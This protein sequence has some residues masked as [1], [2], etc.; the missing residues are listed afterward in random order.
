MATTGQ[1]TVLSMI[2]LIAFTPRPSLGQ[3]AL[4]TSDTRG[5]M[6]FDGIYLQQRTDGSPLT[7]CWRFFADGTAAQS[8]G[9]LDRPE[10]CADNMATSLE[11]G[12]PPR[13]RY[14]LE[15]NRLEIPRDGSA[16]TAE[17][18]VLRLQRGTWAYECRFV[19]DHELKATTAAAQ[20]SAASA[21]SA[22]VAP[23]AAE[24][25]LGR[26][27]MDSSCQKVE[28]T[29]AASPARFPSRVAEI[30]YRIT[31]GSSDSRSTGDLR[32]EDDL[33]CSTPGIESRTC[34]QYGV[35][36]GEPALLSST[37]I[38][39]CADGKPFQP[40]T[41]RLDLIRDGR[42]ARSIEFEIG[43]SNP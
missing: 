14:T 13:Y 10:V 39:R 5:P 21:R 11:Y 6:R 29:A 27:S 7:T 20:S 18:D 42:R 32:I 31:L 17:G 25:A 43:A 37:I 2:A 26:A 8:R 41:Y 1:R 12:G 35:V 22:T 15:G 36:M 9:P 19:S 4:A 38:L 34:N 28:F 3:P 23:P 40:G 16:G 30:A 24:V 33:R